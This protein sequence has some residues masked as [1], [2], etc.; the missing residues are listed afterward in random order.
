MGTALPAQHASEDESLQAA[1]AAAVATVAAAAAAIG[2]WWLWETVLNLAFHEVLKVEPTYALLFQLAA[3]R[4][5][6]TQTPFKITK[7]I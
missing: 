1:A 7:C 5:E 4:R 6:R 2:A 3:G